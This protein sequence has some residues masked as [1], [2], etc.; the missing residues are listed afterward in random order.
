MNPQAGHP[1]A[2]E[3]LTAQ[4][5]RDAASDFRRLLATLAARAKWLGSRDPESAAQET[6]RRSLE[7]PL[8]QSAVTY[9][10]SQD[11]P[12]GIATPEWPLDRLFAWMHAVLFYVVREEQSRVGF[13]REVPMAGA[14]PQRDGAANTLDPADPAPDPLDLLLQKELQGIVGE[15]FPTLELEYRNVLRMR[16]KGMKYG[17][18]AQRLG[19]NEN[20]VATWVSRGVRDLAQ[21]V[22]RRMER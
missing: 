18:I 22:R 2:G 8:S 4:P 3:R 17:E 16:V 13:H 20:T 12:A 6:L 11:L 10:F 15:C 14:N 19:V 7:N 9:Y 21:R 1:I 5:A